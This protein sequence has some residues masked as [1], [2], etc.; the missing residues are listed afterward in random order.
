MEGNKT[1]ITKGGFTRS[2]MICH[3]KQRD[4]HGLASASTRCMS[5]SVFLIEQTKNTQIFF[6]PHLFPLPDF[7]DFTGSRPVGGVFF[8]LRLI[9][10]QSAQKDLLCMFPSY[11]AFGTEGSAVHVSFMPG[12]GQNYS[13]IAC[14]H[15]R[16]KCQ[17][18]N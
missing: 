7:P 9:A 1:K 16:K 17:R 5:C 15:R 11:L 6:S 2:A 10:A 4:E 14:V 3:D 12:L 13:S 8:L 18:V